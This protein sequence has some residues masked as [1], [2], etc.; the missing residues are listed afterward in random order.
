ML[1]LLEIALEVLEVKEFLQ[2]QMHLVQVLIILSFAASDPSLMVRTRP[3]W[4]TQCV[5]AAGPISA[6]SSNTWLQ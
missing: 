5:K 4:L 6:S 3:P 2:L 1:C